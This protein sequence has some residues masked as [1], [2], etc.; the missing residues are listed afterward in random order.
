MPVAKIIESSKVCDGYD[1]LCELEDGTRTVF[2][3]LEEPSDL[4][5]RVASLEAACLARQAQEETQEE[6]KEPVS[7]IDLAKDAKIGELDQW[8]RNK[9]AEIQSAKTVDALR[10]VVV[11]PVD[12]RIEPVEIEVKK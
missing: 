5:D 12:V 3:F 7:E 2:H 11:S 10:K 8:Y 6:A 4:E 1:T 9:L